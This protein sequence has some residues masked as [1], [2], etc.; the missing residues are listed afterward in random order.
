MLIFVSGHLD[1]ARKTGPRSCMALA[2]PGLIAS[3]RRM[4][5]ASP[6]GCQ[7][8]CLH[9]PGH[10]MES[11]TY[12]LQDANGKDHAIFS[13]D[14]LFLGDVGRPTWRKLQTLPRKTWRVYYT[15]A[16]WIKLCHWRMMSSCTRHMALEVL[17]VRI[18]WKRPLIRWATKR[19][20]TMRLT[21]PTN[22]PL[23]KAVTEGLTL[24]PA[25]SEWMWPW[26]KGIREFWSGAEP[27]YACPGTFKLKRQPRRN[28]GPDTGYEV[29]RIFIKAS[30]HS[31]SISA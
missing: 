9:T 3:W 10:T 12:L 24:L 6:L 30:Y 18:W 21:S 4:A 31:Q 29:T 2:N 22:N 16:W 11:T 28:R 25:I 1:L 27:G 20:W 5:N 7:Y 14:T 17:V 19:K 15:T 13:G 26:T 8:Y 23:S